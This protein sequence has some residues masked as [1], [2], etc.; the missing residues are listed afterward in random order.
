[1]RR[2]AQVLGPLIFSMTRAAI[3]YG[4]KVS[5]RIQRSWAQIGAPA[6]SGDH[7]VP[8]LGTVIG[9]TPEQVEQAQSLGDRAWVVLAHLETD[10]FEAEWEIVEIRAQD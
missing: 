8:G 9:I 2:A 4:G 3:A 7:E 10:G 5:L 6:Q 1:M